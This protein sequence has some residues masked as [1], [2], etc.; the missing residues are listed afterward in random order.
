MDEDEKQLNYTITDASIRN[1]KLNLEDR[2]I[3]LSLDIKCEKDMLSEM[4]V[5]Y[6]DKCGKLFFV[7]L[8]V[9]DKN[10]DENGLY[11]YSLVGSI[12]LSKNGTA[13]KYTVSSA[14]LLGED[15]LGFYEDE[16]IIKTVQDKIEYE[17]D[18]PNED[19]TPPEVQDIIVTNNVVSPGDTVD[20]IVKATD[21][22]AGF[23]AQEEAEVDGF[24]FLTY[25]D[26]SVVLLEYDE[27]N[28]CFVGQ[29]QVSE[30]ALE[31][32]YN[33][34]YMV[35]SDTVR[36]QSYYYCDEYSKQ[37]EE[38]LSKAK[39]TVKNKVTTPDNNESTQTIPT[40]TNSTTTATTPTTTSSNK[41]A[42]T[43]TADNNNLLFI[44]ALLVVSSGIMITSNK[45]ITE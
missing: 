45:K 27:K 17:Y 13:G 8:D 21:N 31:G 40:N 36:N 20:I 42:T 32:D 28:E 11:N 44:I 35:V 15:D 3:D 6:T 22:Q 34:N 16:N 26:N 10:M 12:E 4:Y 1:N 38:L 24:V 19:I 14:Y 29:I 25:D 30:D 18:N 7:Y 39:I 5:S 37:D 43:K 23:I 9:I 41:G 2:K 33:V